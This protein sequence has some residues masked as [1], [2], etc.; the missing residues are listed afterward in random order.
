[1]TTSGERYS[2]LPPQTS[3]PIDR[4]LTP[5]KAFFQSTVSGGLLLMAAAA[6]ALM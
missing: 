1:M 4:M 5:F 2:T 6:V 3:P